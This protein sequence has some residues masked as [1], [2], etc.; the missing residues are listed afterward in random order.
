[1]NISSVLRLE[2]RTSPANFK[3]RSVS[4][5]TDIDSMGFLLGHKEV[6]LAHVCNETEE[7]RT[8]VVSGPTMYNQLQHRK[9]KN[10]RNYLIFRY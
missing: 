1:M 8:M 9:V 4:F 10:G 7:V 2:S 3:S 5:Y 6:L